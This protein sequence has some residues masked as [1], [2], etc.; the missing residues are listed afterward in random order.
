V[1]TSAAPPAER[2]SESL[3]ATL[4]ADPRRRDRVVSVSRLP[5]RAARP[6]DWPSWVDPELRERLVASGCARPWSHQREAAEL[7]WAG[8]HV[9]LS[10]GTASGKSLGYRLPVLSRLRA[11]PRATALYLAPTK[12][13]GADQLRWLEELGL[14]GIR[15][16][17]VDGDTPERERDWARAHASW[18]LTNPDLLHHS[19]LPGHRRWRRLLRGLAFV[20]VDECH[21]YRGVFGS[22][23][24]QVLRRL[25]RLCAEYGADPVFVLCSATTADPAQSAGKLTGLPVRAVSRDGSPRGETALVFYEP[26][27]LERAGENGAPVR[28]AATAETAD[29][30]AD[31]VAAGTRTLAF[32]RSRRSAEA[33][34]DATRELLAEVDPA[35][36]AQVAAYRGGY[37]ATERRELERRLRSG[38]LRGLAATSALELGVDVS[39]LDAVL[40][41]GFPG[42]LASVWQQAGRAGRDGRG[43][44]AVLVARDD[45]LDTYLVHHPE[46]VTGRPVEATVLD[47][48]NPHVLGPHLQCAA[49]ESPLTSADLALFGTGCAEQL[50]ALVADGLLRRRPTGWYW[51]DPSR[52]PRV[53]LRGS[54]DQVCLVEAGTGRLL[55]TV[56]ESRADV[57]AHEGAVYVH[58]GAVFLVRSLDLDDGVALLEPSAPDYTTIA[59]QVTDIALSRW[60]SRDGAGGVGWGL[61]EVEV[62]RRAVSYL[63]RRLGTGEVLGEHALDLPERRLATRAV[64]WTVDEPVLR[65]AGVAE[66]DVPG[67]AHAAEHAAIALLPLFATCDRWDIGGVSTARH[68]D[69]G[70]A[71]VF[72]YDGARGGAGFAERGHQRFAAW[73]AATAAAVRSCACATGCPSCVQSPSC[74]NGN[75]PLDKPG[76]VALLEATLAALAVTG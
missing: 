33:V 45:P 61:A 69:T 67:A 76:A 21:A 71:T 17:G 46:A 30:L 75:Q 39:G 53:D 55:G 41:A 38:E 12:A 52:W 68:P 56:D 74:G 44:L 29:L 42:T 11:D 59:R 34:A 19:L 6:V 51:A 2:L 40:I 22:H 54:G 64:V 32:V 57:T 7:A 8:H 62:S 9:V 72:V 20:V 13:L 18:L 4:L 26:P 27:L 31:L 25:R 16:A 10:T 50:A 48:A 65:R 73:V 66:A 1:P 60:L 3:L 36:P 58:Q 35:L 63:R 5:A 47:P 24:A 28:R 37:L 49:R 14:P 43:A 15:G 23:V 70:L